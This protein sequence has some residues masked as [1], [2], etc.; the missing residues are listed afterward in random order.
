MIEL[1]EKIH[2]RHTVLI[3]VD[4]QNDY[5]HPEGALAH[6][7]TDVSSTQAMLP[8]LV[9]L[10]EAARQ[11][12]T[13]IIFIRTTHDEWTDSPARK[14]LPRLRSMPVCRTGTW[15]SEFYG[16][17]PGP[18]DYVITKHRYSAFLDTSLD[19]VLRSVGA[20]TLIVT[21]VS[22]HTCVDCT[23]RDGFQRDYFIVVPDDCTATYSPRVQKATL[24]NLERHYGDVTTSNEI[25]GAWAQVSR[26]AKHTHQA[27]ASDRRSSSP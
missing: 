17:S 6:N 10:I 19:L 1:T 24:A 23:A 4:M 15:G 26:V 13:K 21:G 7:G 18:D 16:V 22:T 27:K 2:P 14:E 9:A 8:R 5:C 25:V 20:R 12:G 3:V 11:A